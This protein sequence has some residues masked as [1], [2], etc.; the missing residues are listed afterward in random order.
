MEIINGNITHIDECIEITIRSEVGKRYFNDGSKKLYNII[1]R[2]I[3]K[4]ELRVMINSKGNCLGF[5]MVTDNGAFDMYPYL[6][7]IMVHE[8]YRS[9]GYGSILMKYYED[10]FYSNSRKLFLLVGNFNTEAI[11]L[12]KRLGYVICGEIE[13]FYT[14]GENEIIMVKS[15]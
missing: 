14:P 4:S 6:H 13:G 7:L 11:K 5:L 8:D 12:Y 2:G 3:K 1:D 15:K 10:E 9:K